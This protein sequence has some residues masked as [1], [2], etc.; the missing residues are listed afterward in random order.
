MLRTTAQMRSVVAKNPYPHASG[1]TLH[2]AFVTDKIDRAALKALDLDRFAPEEVTAIGRELYL[3]LPNG[4]GRAK[5]PPA[6]AKLKGTATA[7]NWNSVTKL[8]AMA[9]ATPN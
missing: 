5:L 3:F 4:M 6:L 7:R 2:V 1:T 9:E 8:L